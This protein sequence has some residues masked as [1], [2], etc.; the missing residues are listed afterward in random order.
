MRTA[1]D[2]VYNNAEGIIMKKKARIPITR[3]ISPRSGVNDR[4]RA[5][6]IRLQVTITGANSSNCSDRSFPR[7]K[8]LNNC[9]DGADNDVSIKY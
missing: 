9:A 8:F 7:P 5:N 4:T 1:N 3:K 6:E 2:I